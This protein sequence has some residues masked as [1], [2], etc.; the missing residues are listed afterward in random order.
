LMYFIDN[1][2]YQNIYVVSKEEELESME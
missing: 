1:F 2:Q